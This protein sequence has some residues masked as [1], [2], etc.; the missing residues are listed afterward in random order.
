MTNESVCI[1]LSAVGVGIRGWR[2][3]RGG[4]LQVRTRRRRGREKWW[5]F[6]SK[7]KEE[8]G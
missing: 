5:T 1:V 4:H 2:R 6:T 8:K 3:R 7:D